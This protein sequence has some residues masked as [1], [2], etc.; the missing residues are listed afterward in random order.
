MRDVNTVVTILRVGM[1]R[2]AVEVQKKARPARH[3]DPIVPS[4]PV[5]GRESKRPI[6]V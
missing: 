5:S 3:E 1:H 6:D 2:P 4:A